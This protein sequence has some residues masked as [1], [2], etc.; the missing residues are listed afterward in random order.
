[1]FKKVLS[2][3]KKV[4][5]VVLSGII[6]SSFAASIC[7]IPTAVADQNDSENLQSSNE[8]AC[9]AA[10][11][12]N[13]D[14]KP[15]ANNS[16][17]ICRVN[18]GH[19]DVF[20]T[21]K[22]ANGKLV[23]GTRGDSF[24]GTSANEI[25][26]DSSLIRFV[27]GKK[28]RERKN[29]VFS[30][31]KQNVSHIYRLPS[32]NETGKLYAGV[33][34]ETLG[35]DSGIKKVTFSFTNATMPKN[36]AVYMAGKDD[37]KILKYLGT[38]GTDFPNEYTVNGKAHVHMDWIFTAPGVYV[39]T[40][41][42][43]A[44]TSD[45]NTLEDT[46]DYTFEVD[47][48]RAK[49]NSEY[50][51]ES[52]DNSDA[53]SGDS[54]ESS[55]SSEN[56]S[57][58]N[59]DENNNSESETDN[60]GSLDESEDEQGSQDEG[61]QDDSEDDSESED[62]SI[63]EESDDFSN[64][65]DSENRPVKAKCL[66][67]KDIKHK[68]NALVISNGHVDIASYTSKSGLSLAVQEDVTGQHVIRHPRTVVFYAGQSSKRNNVWRLPQTQKDGV[69]WVGF[70]NQ[71][72]SPRTSATMY[73]AAI[74]GPGSVR[75]WL[76]GS[77]GERPSE[78]FSSKK[79]AKKWYKIPANTHM[80][81][82]WDFSK[83]GYY[84]LTFAVKANGSI[85]EE[86]FHFAIGVNPNKMPISCSVK[87]GLEEDEGEDELV[88]PLITNRERENIVDDVRPVATFANSASN[89]P[90][91]INAR[92]GRSLGISSGR[93]LDES[94]SSSSNKSK[95]KM[96]TVSLRKSDNKNAYNAKFEDDSIDDASNSGII[97]FFKHKTLLAYS[98][99]SGSVVALCAVAYLGVYILR[100]YKII[101][102]NSGFISMIFGN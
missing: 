32:Q 62:E 64:N 19:T 6:V 88:K 20:A 12:K 60:D 80:H 39:L 90:R 52:S 73:L 81:V 45:G 51:F 79:G 31:V 84:T 30:F 16:A 101:S 13:S 7:V 65:E 54:G 55:G 37:D 36:G 99:L 17:K 68:L 27:V 42:A 91:V 3:L 93:R 23:L 15:S 56:S 94:L 41:K 70:N 29:K 76:Q 14:L 74:K 75:V 82:N 95:G 77:L 8:K 67:F 35:D 1:M 59:T 98:I 100:K 24:P 33:S 21:Y 66:T 10:Q 40:V 78:M 58:N 48:K 4:S 63:D 2:I 92:S 72:L 43:V 71:N 9:V 87:G 22:D 96:P 102:L 25:R 86:K 85:S 26:Y 34:T 53:G 11:L 38:N 61:S 47:L 49:E 97:G 50:D 44:F 69:P 18:K 46:Q 28:S 89:V 5:S 57:E 83:A